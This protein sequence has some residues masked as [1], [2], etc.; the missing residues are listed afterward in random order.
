MIKTLFPAQRTGAQDSYH[1]STEGDWI[2]SSLGG[3][4][5]SGMCRCPA[6]DDHK[7]SLHVS[8]Q[9]GR[10]LVKCHAGCSQ[11][12]VIDA[13]KRRGLWP[14]HGPEI[15]P[16]RSAKQAE[17]DSQHA[18]YRQLRTVIAILRK[19]SGDGGFG[20]PEAYFRNRGLETPVTALTLKREEIDELAIGQV[21]RARLYGDDDPKPKFTQRDRDAI[22]FPVI[23]GDKIAAVHLTY[24]E[25]ERDRRVDDK[26]KARQLIG[27]AKGGFIPLSGEDLYTAP[28]LV[29][30]EGVESTL[31]AMQHAGLPGMAAVSA[32][33]LK[34][35]KLPRKLFAATEVIVVAD[36]DEPGVSAANE[37]AKRL[38]REGYRVRIAI[39]EGEGADWN[40]VLREH[41][42]PHAADAILSANIVH[43]SADDDVEP[44]GMADLMNVAFPE[45]VK[46]QKP[47][48]PMPGLAMI[49]GNA[50]H[51]KTHLAMSVAYAVA[52]GT[53]ILGWDVERAAKVLYVEGEM[54][55]KLLQDRIGHLGPPLAADKLMFLCYADF[56]A[57][58]R[59][60]PD[61]GSDQGRDWLDGKIE[62]YGIDFIV[63]D[64]MTWLVR[65]ITENDTESWRGIHQWMLRHQG[66][67]RSLLVVHHDNARGTM[68]GN[69]VQEAPLY[70]RLHIRKAEDDKQPQDGTLFTLKFEKARGFF[71]AESAPMSIKLETVDD[72]YRWSRDTTAAERDREI[73]EAYDRLKSIRQV[74]RE[75]GVTK[76]AVETALSLSRAHGAQRNREA[77]EGESD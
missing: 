17:A 35:V 13:L 8:V 73:I 16:E 21:E 77:I 15:K 45:L 49:H 41:G 62:K 53:P 27:A 63:L 19:A 58:S 23:N 36:N 57:K 68:R 64:S 29:I 12:A 26:G 6:H 14:S 5:D 72:M 33:G 25:P 71:G 67:G 69:Q 56:A 70:S 38:T 65:S 54:P 74:T 7:P 61:I 46:L 42:A 75:L 22:V 28:R 32:S 47:W 2:V 9:N 60:V 34:A 59:D 24:L 43:V 1:S 30:G 48:L 20:A 51:G 50:G 52:S 4:P 18:E 66:Q 37:C 11:D 55:G 39:P 40:D 44:R 76:H 31:S 10:V 3:N